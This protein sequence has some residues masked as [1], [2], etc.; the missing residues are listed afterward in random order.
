MKGKSDKSPPPYSGGPKLLTYNVNHG[1]IDEDDIISTV[2]PRFRVKGKD[3][4]GFGRTH[5][6]IDV[7]RATP[8]GKISVKNGT[9]KAESKAYNIGYFR[10]R[11]KGVKK[12]WWHKVDKEF[13]SDWNMSENEQVITVFSKHH[14]QGETSVELNT[15]AGFKLDES[16]ITVTP[17]ATLSSKVKITVGSAKQRVKAQLSRR[18]VLSTIV[19][20]GITNETYTDG[21]VQYN[22]KKVG[23]FSFYFKHYYT[24]L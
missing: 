7:Y 17:S 13:D 8:D 6:K 16:K 14:F 19:G 1:E 18:Q 12:G 22:V 4:L 2:M 24:D 3:W 21:G 15:K 23:I 5:Q 11:K 10:F 9:I 20:K